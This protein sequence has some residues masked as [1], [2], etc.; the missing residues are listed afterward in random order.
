MLT[1]WDFCFKG[2]KFPRYTFDS[3]QPVEQCT[4]CVKPITL[5]QSCAVQDSSISLR[6]ARLHVSYQ[7]IS[8]S[9]DNFYRQL[10]NLTVRQ[11]LEVTPTE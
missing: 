8:K 10:R 5:N 4:K 9:I 1:C 6:D 11:I 3:K 2:K 7:P